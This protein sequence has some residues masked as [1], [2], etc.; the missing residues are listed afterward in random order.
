MLLPVLRDCKVG[1]FLK[2]FVSH[3]KKNWFIKISQ[4]IITRNFCDPRDIYYRIDI[5][6]PVRFVSLDQWNAEL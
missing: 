1:C 4:I 3:E 5:L 6:S 2:F